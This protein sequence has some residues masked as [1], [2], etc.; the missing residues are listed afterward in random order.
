MVNGVQCV[1]INGVHKWNSNAVNQQALNQSQK[2]MLRMV[3]IGFGLIMFDGTNLALE[4]CLTHNGWENHN[5]IY[6]QAA[7]S[8]NIDFI[9][10]NKTPHVQFSCLIEDIHPNPDDSEKVVKV[11][12]I[13]PAA[14]IAECDKNPTCKVRIVLHNHHCYKYND[15]NNPRP[16]MS[17]TVR[18]VMVAAFSSL[19]AVVFE[20][21]K[22]LSKYLLKTLR[23]IKAWI[24]RRSD[25]ESKETQ[26]IF[27]R[28]DYESKETQ[29]GSHKSILHYQ[30][31]DD[32]TSDSC[33]DSQNTEEIS[34][35][36]EHVSA[37]Q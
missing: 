24:F 34:I 11:P 1:I 32:L 4:Q 2:M 8:N 13:S 30:C 35:N 37:M 9:P 3:A 29:T 6:G 19:A 25:Y 31:T 15:Y 16:A 33:Y 18:Y 5:C 17:N 7:S 14:E 10:N 22:Y 27:Q 12:W 36:M 21:Y 26:T 20:H 23:K 28:S